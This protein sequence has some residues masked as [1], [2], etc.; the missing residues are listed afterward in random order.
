V[1]FFSELLTHT[2]G[3]YARVPFVPSAWQRDEVLVPLFGRVVFDDVRGRYVRRY[4]ILY[5]CVA[6]KNGKTEL[7][8][9]I[10]LY[11]LCADGEAG[12]EVYGLALD[13][14]QAGLV[15]QVAARMVAQ[16]AVLRSR[17]VVVRGAKR[18]VEEG[19]GSFYQVLAGDAQGNLGQNPSGAYI[20]ELLTQKDRELFDAV[21]TGMGTRAQPLLLLATTA[22]SDPSS[23]AA[24]E[25]EWS[26]RVAADPELEPD[27]LVVIHAADGDA[28]W[29]KP[30][31]WRQANP[32]LGDFLE[33]RTL[34]SECRTAV[35]NPAAERSFRQYRLNQPQS[36]VGRAIAM[37]VWD[38]G[39]GP[40][41]SAGLPEALAGAECYAGLDLAT[42]QDLAAYALVFPRP[43]GA[44]A[45]LWR[46]FAPAGR[47]K[48][49]DRR[50]AGQAAL[51]VARG[52]LT[53]TDSVV[54]D[55]DA[56]RAALDAD[57]LAFDLREVAFDPWNAVQLATSLADEGW[58]MIPFPQ[59]A[60]AMSAS[61]VELLRLV[62][63]GLL[64][65][66]GHGLAR[67]QASNVVTR[68]DSTG[69]V[70]VDKQ[71]SADK[72]D[73]VVAAVMGLDRALRRS[74]PAP[75]Y[76]AAGF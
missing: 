45:V 73:G 71:R 75:D 4:R 18:I 36:K 27:R 50:T 11:L 60:R 20:D 2:K 12:A 22:E 48:E 23:F 17:L 35:N 64:H 40:V 63:A 55:Y 31:T 8:A 16:S 10:V 5:L 56:V 25:R 49:L 29:T 44:Y 26:E 13:T 32:A 7:L 6:R 30:A 59:Q 9:G 67:W 1:A 15:Y 21:K 33:M 53:L 37:K 76:A 41:A 38:G 68:T 34:A 58:T 62:A 69:N 24:S 14:E 57:R 66:G 39:A 46:H 51:W 74:A 61:T 3:D 19:S 47:L 70:K 42:T 28:D 52:E 65:H 72:V 54:T 43:D